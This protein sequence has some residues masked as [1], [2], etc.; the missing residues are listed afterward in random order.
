MP[1]EV[2]SGAA[3]ALRGVPSK[4][5]R[6]MA[7][8]L[9]AEV[10]TRGDLVS[11]L[12]LGGAEQGA[13]LSVDSRACI[14]RAAVRLRKPTRRTPEIHLRDAHGPNSTIAVSDGDVAIV[15]E[16]EVGQPG[17]VEKRRQG[18]DGVA[19]LRTLS[20]GGDGDDVPIFGVDGDEADAI[21]RVVLG[22]SLLGR[23]GEVVVYLDDACGPLLERAELARDVLGVAAP[24]GD[25]DTAPWSVRGVKQ[26]MSQSF[27]F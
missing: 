14:L 19:V 22:L 8:G 27:V 13:D 9:R 15:L 24:G 26:L 23:P 12:H 4:R 21:V 3:A 16:S 25:A 18:L 1:T 2:W 5:P 20:H 10:K 17:V 7:N 6:C 11:G